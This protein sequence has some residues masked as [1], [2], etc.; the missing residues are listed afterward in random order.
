MKQLSEL[1]CSTSLPPYHLQQSSKP[2]A[3]GPQGHSCLRSCSPALTS[4]YGP[5]CLTIYVPTTSFGSLHAPLLSPSC[6]LSHGPSFP[7]SPVFWLVLI[8]AYSSFLCQFRCHSPG[9]LLW[10]L[11]SL[12]Q[13][14]TIPCCWDCLIFCPTAH[15]PQECEGHASEHRVIALHPVIFPSAFLG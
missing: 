13:Q 7:S 5:Y 11:A 6:F 4:S 14:S 1:S 3:S 2:P 8:N 9:A 10:H 12:S 15:K